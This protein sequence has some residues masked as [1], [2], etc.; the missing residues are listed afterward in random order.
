MGKNIIVLGT[1][2]GDEGKGKIVDL[3]TEDAAAVVRFQGGHN[4]GHTVVIEG[5]KTILHLIPSGILHEGV[6]CLIG[7]GVVLSPHALME[8]IKMLE[9]NNISARSLIKISEACTLI[10]PYH[11]ALDQARE[12]AKGKAAIG[13]TGRGIGPAYEDKVARRALRAGDLAND[14]LLASKL[15]EILEYHNF[16]LKNYYKCDVIDYQESL[17]DIRK[18]SE[19]LIPMIIDTGSRLNELHAEGKNIMFEG[20]QGTWLDIDHGTYPFVTSS[21]TTAGGAATGTGFGPCYF[22]YILGITKAYT[23]RVGSGPFPTELFDDIGEHLA[24]VGHEFGATT[25]RG[26]RCGWFDAVALR[27]SAQINSL[28]GL[29]ITKLDV[30]DELET[31]KICTAYEMNGKVIDIP[32]IGAEAFAEC[33]PVYEDHPGWQSNTVGATNYDDLPKKAIDYLNRLSEVTGVPIDIIS[34]GPDRA[35]T[36]VL[37]NPFA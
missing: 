25:G 29:C 15:E 31:I 4:A 13:T 7:N 33:K 18:L 6:E 12:K 36:I 26:R 20:A 32:P 2:W 14:A 22:N 28:T 1:Q 27:R 5:K 37:K 24:K 8:E 10:L 21:N 34:T 35:E 9:E 30:L 17:D 3:L 16:M 11:I 23:T 19:D